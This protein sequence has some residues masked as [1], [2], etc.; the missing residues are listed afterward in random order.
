MNLLLL[1]MNVTK[2]QDSA[3]HCKPLLRQITRDY[4]I[5]STISTCDLFQSQQGRTQDTMIRHSKGRS[6]FLNF[7]DN[8]HPGG[9]IRLAQALLTKLL[10]F[11]HVLIFI[12]MV[13]T[14]VI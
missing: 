1:C 6:S 2:S 5:L 4:W 3:R 12:L 14:S 13:F 10:V 7:L 9:V 8:Q 11:C